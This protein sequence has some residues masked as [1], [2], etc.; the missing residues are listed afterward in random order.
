MLAVSPVA[1][2]YDKDIDR[3]I[4]PSRSW[5]SGPRKRRRPKR[6]ERA[7]EEA[8]KERLKG[9][10]ARG[11]TRTSS[12]Q[13]VGE[14]A[15]KSVTRTI[16]SSLGR[17]LVRG[18]LGKSEARVLRGLFQWADKRQVCRTLLPFVLIFERWILRGGV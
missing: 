12:R 10:R 16:A 15:I 6:P 17:A 18:I 13:T 1:G 2:Q 4:P 3:G 5:A 14:A 7:R 8:E 9:S 11:R